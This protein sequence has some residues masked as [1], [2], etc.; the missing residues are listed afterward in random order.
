M[1]RDTVSAKALIF[2]ILTAARS[3]ETRGATLKE[4]DYDAAIWIVPGAR[5]KSG[6]EH[7]VPLIDEA[8]AILR[9]LNHLEDDQ[10]TV[11]FPNS[12]TG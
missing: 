9:G 12:R 7:R 1:E 2:T 5:T 11:L 3:G 4:I 6:R 10:G 8:L